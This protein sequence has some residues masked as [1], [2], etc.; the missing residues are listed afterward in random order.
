[1]TTDPN[2]PSDN[3][4]APND[5]Q[6]IPAAEDQGDPPPAVKPR[7]VSLAAKIMIGLVLGLACG[8][9]FGEMVTWLQVVGIIFIKLLQITVIPYISLSLI[10]GIG[11][12]SF[13]EVKANLK[14]GGIIFLITSGIT[15]AVVMLMPLSFPAWPSASFFSTNQIEEPPAIDFLDLFIPSNPFYSYANA[16]VPA[17]VLFS[18]L[19]GVALIGM[20]RKSVLLE[21]LG[22]L[23]AA[24]MKI[25]RIIT[26]TAPVGVFA[27]IAAVSGTFAVEDLMRLQVYIVLYV[28]IAL[29]LSLVLLPG[30]IMVFTPFRYR[31]I[32]RTLR[33]PLI[34]AFATGSSLII[35]PILIDRCQ[36]LVAMHMQPP[37]DKEETDAS[38][39]M[40]IPAFY[41]LPSPAALLALSFILYAG[42]HTG[43]QISAAAYPT[44]II[45]GVP[46][47]FGGILL[48]I[49]F[50][51][52]QLQLPSD[53][54]QLFILIQVFIARFGT[55][56]SAMHYAAIALIGTLA[57]TGQI[58][59][60]KMRL[61]RVSLFSVV[62]M[63]P[64][65]LGVRLF[66]THVVTA[67]YTKAEMLKRLEF[68]EPPQSAKVY[69]DVP[70]YLVQTNGVPA[71]LE[72]ITS[73]GVLRVCYQPDE[74]PSAFLN[75]ADPPQ[76][77]GFDVEMA[78]RF[79]RN[80]QLPLEF[81]PAVSQN[82]ARDLL[83]RGACDIY[84][85]TLPV[86]LSR[87][88]IFGMSTPI[89]KSSLGLIVKDYRRDD[90]RNWEDIEAQGKSLRLGVENT[91][92][93]IAYLKRLLKDAQIVPLDSMEQELALLASGAEGIDAVADMAEEGA[94]QTLLYPHFTLVVPKPTI[95]FPVAY[96]V[97]R[98][99][100]DLLVSFN[101]WLLQ[102]QSTGMVDELYRHWMLG[103]AAKEV[104]PPRWSVIRDVLGWVD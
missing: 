50:M 19:V 20:P 57:W 59:L 32:V 48:A 79:A 83:D 28:L 63:A 39:E 1:M 91:P 62:L 25:T 41:T 2:A 68:R 9:F 69:T 26:R 29:L 8:L 51:L 22:V 89:R 65:L 70:D 18:I 43:S 94:A 54:F 15:V 7:R 82:D 92:S 4:R 12:L 75:T 56:M 99:N 73:R 52:K 85:R 93:N 44:L 10:T 45:T 58:R 35:L 60:R 27:L 102:E 86:T 24:M 66:Y 71:G 98:G 21:P 101:T 46:S 67:P 53:L 36:R 55:M 90:F 76:L 103:G 3:K 37:P 16:L 77:V 61:I 33:T 97:A 104:K 100:D 49:P 84:M 31:D 78:H 23:H 14:M 42:W 5:V 72:Q 88:R 96:S 34:T 30:I 95:F 81:L 40:L 47:L 11:R 17:V 13:E 64:V 74:Y 80:L 38:I 87:S 6:E